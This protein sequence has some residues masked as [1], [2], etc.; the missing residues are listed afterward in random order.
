VNE[1]PFVSSRSTTSYWDYIRVE[2]LLRLQGGL[3]GTDAELT[4]D[5]VR[6]IV[7]H[8]IDELWMKLVLRE[9]ASARDLFRQDHVPETALAAAADGLH[10][11]TLTLQLMAD[12][13]RLMETMRTQAYLEFRDK[14]SPASGFQSAQMREIEILMGLEDDD[15]IRF[16]EEGSYLDALRGDAGDRSPALQRVMARLADRP[17]LKDAVYGWLARAPIQ[18]STPDQP[19]DEAVVMAWIE[20]FLAR[21][22]AGM[23]QRKAESLAEQALTDADVRRL[24][25]RYAA[26]LERA[27]QYLLATEVDDQAQAA[28][29]RRL[30]AA[31]LFIESHRELPLLSWP[32]EIIDA[33]IATEQSLLVFRQRH[34]RMV[35]RVIGRRVGT[36]GSDGVDYLDRTALEYRVFKEVWAA[37]T[38]LL[39]RDLCPP[40][41][42]ID[43][44]G[45]RS[46]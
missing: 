42:N 5:E 24:E 7:I 13:F 15:R 35:E 28:R 26:E 14:L 33:L 34:A 40:V 20:D 46:E 27:R 10:R 44:Y 22:S 43:F 32:A 3:A 21:Q 41:A 45:L 25:A 17:S 39:R 37:R 4:D 19:D 31:I 30:R 38:M 29:T 11:V 36:G 16:G 9:L 23:E 1:R 6:F 8:Q 12:H 18:A 2:E